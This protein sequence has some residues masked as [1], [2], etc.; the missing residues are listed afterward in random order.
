MRRNK[1]L[2]TKIDFQFESSWKQKDEKLGNKL[3]GDVEK[4]SDF[5]EFKLAHTYTIVEFL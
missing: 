1:R 2:E 4:I 5:Y 3:T